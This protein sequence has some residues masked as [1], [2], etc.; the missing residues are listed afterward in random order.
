MFVASP[1]QASKLLEFLTG[2]ALLFCILAASRAA[3][4]S[5][6]SFGVITAAL[7]AATEWRNRR[8]PLGL[9]VDDREV[10]LRSGRRE[11]AALRR[12]E[13]AGGRVHLE[14]AD[15]RGRPAAFLVDADTGARVCLAGFSADAVPAA[16][17]AHGWCTAVLA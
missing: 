6:V 13:G 15:R 8:P 17:T 4:A 1:R 12:A 3:V 16:C 2:V 7:F 10:V 11:V 5:A 9:T 14:S